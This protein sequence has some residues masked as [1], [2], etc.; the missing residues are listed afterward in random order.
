MKFAC[1]LIVFVFLASAPMAP[2][3]I[4]ADEGIA[5]SFQKMITPGSHEELRDLFAAENY[6]WSTLEQGVPPIILATLPSDLEHVTEVSERKNLFFL[7]LLPMVLLV[8]EEISV[9]R[10]TLIGVLEELDTGIPLSSDSLDFLTELMREYRVEGD[11]ETDWSVRDTL[12]KRVDI[13]PASLVLAQAANETGYGTSRFARHGNNLF[14]EWTY[15]PGS[16]IVPRN[17]PPGQ[18]YEVRSFPT[19]LDSVRSYMRNINTHRAY[20]TFR[21]QRAMLRAEGRPLQGRELA[22][23]LK[24]YSIRR[25]AYV[26]EIRDIIRSNRLSILSSVSLRR[27]PPPAVEERRKGF[28]LF[29]TAPEIS[30]VAQ[31]IKAIDSIAVA[32]SP[33]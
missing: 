12:L 2:P 31:I 16:G 25:E 5:V 15:S 10:Q 23:G 30:R 7:S 4:L 8:N 17:R 24:N 11:P 29:S 6:S 14:G 20:G 21:L 9:K 32:S 33:P 26:V 3:G 1:L 19:L 28:G 27:P 13:I 22:H 18:K